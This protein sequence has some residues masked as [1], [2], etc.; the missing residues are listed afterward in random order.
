VSK[1]SKTL[2]LPPGILSL[3]ISGKLVHLVPQMIE[4]HI[5]NSLSHMISKQTLLLSVPEVTVDFPG[6]R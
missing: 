4:E 2:K 3:L 1:V 5:I 6:Q